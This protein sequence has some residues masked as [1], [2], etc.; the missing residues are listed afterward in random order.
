MNSIEISTRRGASEPRQPPHAAGRTSYLP[1]YAHARESTRETRA[2]VAREDAY[3]CVEW[4]DYENEMLPPQHA[5]E[6]RRA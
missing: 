1:E 3:G 2:V 5:G 6:R 4:F